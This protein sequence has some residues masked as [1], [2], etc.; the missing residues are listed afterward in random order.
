MVEKVLDCCLPHYLT[1]DS[2]VLKVDNEIKLTLLA[3]S[4]ALSQSH[5]TVKAFS[6]SAVVIKLANSFCHQHH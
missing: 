2:K 1:A 6:E 5:S 3:S 4:V